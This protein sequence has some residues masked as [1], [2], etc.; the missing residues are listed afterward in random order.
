M[1]FLRG[2]LGKEAR[3]LKVGEKATYRRVVGRTELLTYMGVSGDLNP[4]Y[5]DSAYAGRT[6]WGR[7]VL[8]PPLLASA[9]G[10]AVSQV[11]PGR[12][13]MVIAHQYKMLA[14]VQVE[15]ELTVHLEVAE[16][17]EQTG[18]VLMR[19]E[20]TVEGQRVLEGELLVE[21]PHPLKPILDHAY[22]N[23]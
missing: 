17:R 1:G 18:Q 21:P 7:P 2:P 11:L 12:G 19:Y 14:P 5:T 10:A 22:E 4:L 23:F 15:S 8:P 20:M 6:R 13:T 9:A 16:I 3:E